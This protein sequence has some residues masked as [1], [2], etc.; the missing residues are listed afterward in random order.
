MSLARNKRGMELSTLAEIILV[1]IGAGFL[2]SVFLVKS[3]QAEEKTS[4]NL[5]RGF[6]ALRF[7]TIVETPIGN[8]NVA[9]RACKTIDKKDLPEKEYKDN[10]I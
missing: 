6:N 7:G 1:L 10:P 9:P 3:S 5:C 2:L 4:E 8:Y